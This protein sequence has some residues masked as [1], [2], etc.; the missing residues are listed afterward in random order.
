MDEMNLKEQLR[1]NDKVEEKI[2]ET[3]AADNYLPLLSIL[4]KQIGKKRCFIAPVKEKESDDGAQAIEFLSW[5]LPEDEDAYLVAFTSEHELKKGPDTAYVP[6][7]IRVL[8]DIVNDTEALSG[9]V[10]NPWGKGIILE[11]KHIDLLRKNSLL[12]DAIRFATEKHEG[13]CRKGTMLP[14]IVHPIETM[15]ILHSMNAGV[16]LMMAGV[17][18]DTLEDTET[19]YDELELLFGEKVANL[20]QAHT[21]DKLKS[22]EERKE[23]EIK[24]TIEGDIN[25]KALVL[26]DK[27]ANLRAIAR[28]Y[29]R[30]GEELW[31]RFTKGK[32]KQAWYYSTIQDALWE[33]QL[34]PDIKDAYWEFVGLY[35]D[36]FV[37]YY[38]DEVKGMLYQQDTNG[39][40][41]ALKKGKPQWKEESKISKHAV[42]LERKHAER[43]EDNWNEPF[44]KQHEAD[45]EDARYYLFDSARRSV[46]L[47][48]KDGKLVLSVLDFGAECESINGKDEYEFWYV[49]DEDNTKRF[50]VQLRFQYGTR[51]KLETILKKAFG[52][53]G[54]PEAFRKFCEEVSVAYSFGSY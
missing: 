36:V 42:Q 45:L 46:A 32:D 30:I 10:I 9:M 7:D 8:L 52:E 38:M 49:L 53:D 14:Y 11:Q 48:I 17:L 24:D 12:H 41:F 51:Y 6:C 35:K 43:I 19:T 31:T 28:D 3:L 20:V 39:D 22:W 33:T 26:A 2:I 18:H 21:E 5:Q 54:G 37:T 29:E 23:K 25:L 16:E 34:Y 13:Q 50:L 40:I 44:W 1:D 47:T 27:L 4:Q 15:Q